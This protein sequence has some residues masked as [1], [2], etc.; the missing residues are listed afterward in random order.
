MIKAVRSGEG[1]REVARRHKVSP[2][3]VSFWVKRTSGKRLDRVDLS[4]KQSG[5]CSPA[6]RTAIEVEDL[7]ITLRR[8]LKVIC[9]LGEYGGEAIRRELIARGVANIPSVRTIGRILERYGVTGGKKR[10]RRPSPPKGWYLPEVAD[11]R[12]ELDSFDY[13]EDLSLEGGPVFNVLN[14]VS[15]HGGL[16]F[17]RIFTRMRSIDTLEAISDHRKDVGLPSYAQF[18]NGTV[19]QGPH[20][21]K[22]TVGRVTRFCLGLGVTVVFATPAEHG[23]QN[24]IES[25]NHRWQDKI[26]NRFMFGSLDAVQEQSDRY[27]LAVRKRNAARIDA[28]P[29]RRPFPADLEIDL[30]MMPCGKII[31]IR[32]TNDSGEASLLGR[33]FP[34]DKHWTH[35]LVRSEVDLE[36]GMIFFYRLR[37]SDHTN[38][39]L[40]NEVAYS[41]PNRSFKL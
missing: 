29:D 12:C 21:H 1:V 7:I 22:D 13:V 39:P 4:D 30:T 6:N 5:P 11:G 32:R 35:R 36:I 17:S 15:I 8:E 14:G 40:L 10:T 18:D 28:A 26:W 37:R 41:L 20:N 25:Y 31:F 9:D 3:T 34:V 24:A 2:S 23:I 38:Q 33:S 27:V 16:P 19:F